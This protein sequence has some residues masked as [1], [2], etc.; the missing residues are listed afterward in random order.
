MLAWQLVAIFA[1]VVVFLI[2]GRRAALAAG[3]GGCLIVLGTA[4]MA[5]RV[6]G[7]GRR[8]GASSTLVDMIVGMV[9]K[10]VVIIAG[11]YVLLARWQMPGL[12]V[13]AGMGTAMAVNLMALRF[14]DKT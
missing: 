7:G 3:L 4:L 13:L 11:L 10:W 9:L 12:A 2:Q 8:L 1:C 6:F 5:L 14:K